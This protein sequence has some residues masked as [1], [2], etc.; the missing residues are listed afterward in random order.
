MNIFEGSRRIALAI[1]ALWVGGFVIAGLNTET[2]AYATYI[3]SGYNA[4][5][6]LKIDGGC[7]NDGF[8]D[9]WSYH[10]KTAKGTAVTASLCFEATDGFQGGKRL[11]PYKLDAVTNKVW[12]NDSWSADV[13]EYAKKYR[14]KFQLPSADFDLLDT[15][16]RNRWWTEI[17]EGFSWMIGGLFI[18]YVVVLAIGWVVRGFM[19][20]PKGMDYKPGQP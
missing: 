5:A 2:K 12:G 17:K 9:F 7:S 3:V 4:Q 8:N 13:R 14:E 18:F 11:V 15:M 19:G 16:A 6:F 20:I 1:A 10:G